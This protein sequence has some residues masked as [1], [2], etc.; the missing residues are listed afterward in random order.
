MLNPIVDR[1]SNMVLLTGILIG[2]MFGVAI[3]GWIQDR[4]WKGYADSKQPVF[5]KKNRYRVEKVY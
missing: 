4:I 3:G 5:R 2:L 1:E